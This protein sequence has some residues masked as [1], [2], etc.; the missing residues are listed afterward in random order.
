MPKVNS[1]LIRKENV[2][3]FKIVDRMKI[4]LL[5]KDF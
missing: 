2:N 4:N 5:K 3:Y 1:M